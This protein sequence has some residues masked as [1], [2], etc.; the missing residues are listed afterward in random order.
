EK[1]V[2]GNMKN[3]KLR[4]PELSN[5]LNYSERQ[6]AR[7]IKG[8]TG[9][10]TVEL[11]LDIRLR[12]AYDLLAKRKFRTISEVHYAVGI[13]SASYFTKKFQER[14]GIKPSEV[15]GID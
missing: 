2:V 5:Y 14:F 4:M 9:M 3:G 1:Y 6:L 7:L 15:S 13:D 8:I 12:T 11:V 10:T